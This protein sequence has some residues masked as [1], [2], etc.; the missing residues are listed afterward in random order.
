MI[1]FHNATKP[2]GQII[3]IDEVTKENRAEHYY[4]VGCGEE[5]SAVLGD[6]REHH[7]RHKEAHCSWESYLH[8][9]GK[10]KLKQKF[11]TQKEFIVKYYVDFH[12]EKSDSCKLASLYQNK[13]NQRELLSL[14]LKDYYD[15]C[16][17][18][19]TYKGFRADLLLTNKAH[20]E[21]EPLFLEISVT[22]DCDPKKTALGSL[23]IELKIENE[24]DVLRPIVEEDCL[25]RTS[26]YEKQNK[27]QSLPAIRF[28]NFNRKIERK[29]PFDRFWIS[30]DS[31]GFL[32]GMCTQKDLTCK[33][34]ADNHK[35]ESI[36]ELVIPTGLNLNYSPINLYEVGMIKAVNSGINVKDCLFCKRYNVCKLTFNEEVED[37]LTGEKKVIPRH[38]SIRD[39]S[40]IIDLTALASSCKNYSYNLNNI[41]RILRRFQQLPDWEWEKN[42]K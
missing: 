25:S 2:D 7:F 8:K 5:M 19:G 39:Y 32:R 33:N 41:N 1:K 22:H 11:D 16:E 17:E 13:C 3:H 37:K 26:Q 27:R 31:K 15:T 36:Y 10:K 38:I 40:N 9:L 20:P 29:R 12:C 24:N 21:Q 14:N 35:K 23:I 6:I 34:I 42:D 18:E 30:K 28:Y 4:C